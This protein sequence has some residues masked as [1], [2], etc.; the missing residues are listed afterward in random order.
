MYVFCFLPKEN[1]TKTKIAPKL[2][3][4]SDSSLLFFEHYIEAALFLHTLDNPVKGLVT[5]CQLL[6][7]LGYS[8]IFVNKQIS[9]TFHQV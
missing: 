7:I 3:L 2:I 6:V 9:Q 1:K 4:G 5:S 8:T